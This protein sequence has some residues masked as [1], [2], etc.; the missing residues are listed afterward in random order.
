MKKFAFFL[1]LML[2]PPAFADEPV[3]LTF[4]ANEGVIIR[5][6]DRAVAIDTPASNSY[7]ETFALPSAEMLDAMTT[8]GDPVGELDAILFTHI[9]GDHFDAPDAA[10]ILLENPGRPYLLA[11]DQV[12]D[13]FIEAGGDDDHAL[14]PRTVDG[15]CE[16]VDQSECRYTLTMPVPHSNRIALDIDARPLFHREEIEHWTYRVEMGGV[17]ILHLGDTQPQQADFSIWDGV[18]FDVI[19]YPYWFLQMPEGVAFLEAHREARAIAFHIP[20]AAT[21]AEIVEALNGAEYLH[22]EGETR[23]LSE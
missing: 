8:G 14:R 20:A 22:T 4:I 9:H 21:D 2:A 11:A 23:I 10:A 19:L 17:S 13:A 7:D 16:T 18:T 15:S 3:E 5:H 6:G 12:V 1:A